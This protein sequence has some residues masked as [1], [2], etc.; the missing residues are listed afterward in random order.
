MSIIG[1]EYTVTTENVPI[2]AAQ[3]LCQI[4][5]P[6][7]SG[8]V[9]LVKRASFGVTNTA[10]V[11]SQS[12]RLQCRRLPTAVT[13]GSGAGSSTPTPAA[14][15]GDTAATFSAVMNATTKAT[16]SGTAVILWAN[17]DFAISGE[18]H[19]P[20]E[21]YVIGQGQS[22]VFELLSTVNG[23]LNGSTSVTVEEIG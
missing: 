8:K 4:K 5:N 16:T 15:P 21:A 20:I 14:Q 9:L 17:G 12:I 6:A 22:F 23:T 10:T 11:T 13:D 1:R 2:S 19:V 18:D 7:S 3:D